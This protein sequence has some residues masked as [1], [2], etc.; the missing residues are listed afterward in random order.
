MNSTATTLR[1]M[2]ETRG[3]AAKRRRAALG[4]ARDRLAREAGVSVRTV[5]HY[6]DDARENMPTGARIEAALDRLETEREPAPTSS[7]NRRASDTPEHRAAEQV[8]RTST[9]ERIALRFLSDGTRA[10]FVVPPGGSVPSDDEL[11]AALRE[12]RGE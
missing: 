12:A 11:E 3:Q 2:A 1:P 6:E 8:I 9:G 4:V 5:K 7:R 10:I